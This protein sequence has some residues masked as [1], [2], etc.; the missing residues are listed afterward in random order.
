MKRGLWSAVLLAAAVVAVQPA[1]A[2][3]T[4]QCLPAA[5]VRASLAAEG[6]NPVIVGNRTGYGYPT[7]LIFFANADGSKGYLVR[8]DKPLG[9]EAETAC[10]DSVYRDVRL[11]DVGKPGVPPWAL[12][13]DSAAQT[14]D[15]CKRDRLG[16]QEFCASNDQGL[17]NLES[18]GEH[19]ML[20]ATG[21][22][23]NPRDKPVRLE[24]KIV[25]PLEPRAATGL[26]QAATREGASYVLSAYGSGSFTQYGT[27]MLGR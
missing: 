25:L 3:E 27:A 13:H 14:A 16:Y 26:L 17:E 20:V 4:G 24:Q 21:T 2:L 6:Q 19:V 5:Q 1:Q 9:Q 7:A 23:I 15:I 22:A 18:H 12:M 8:G 10:I 11:N